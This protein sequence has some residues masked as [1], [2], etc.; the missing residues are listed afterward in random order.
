MRSISE[1]ERDGARWGLQIFQQKNIVARTKADRQTGI[2]S[3]ILTTP[4][5]ER[6]T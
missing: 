1:P 2:M 6:R 3:T 5:R 4:K